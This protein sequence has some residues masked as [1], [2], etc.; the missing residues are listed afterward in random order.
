M[1]R[2]TTLLTL[3]MMTLAVWSQDTIPRLIISEVS[4]NNI[5]G[6]LEITNVGDTALNL[7]QFGITAVNGNGRSHFNYSFDENGN[8]TKLVISASR[9]SWTTHPEMRTKLSGILEAGESFV[10]APF[11]DS[12]R[13]IYN[14]LPYPYTHMTLGNNEAK[15]KFTD[16][17]VLASEGIF[18]PSGEF[19]N[20]PEVLAFGIDSIV[21][22]YDLFWMNTIGGHCL[23]YFPPNDSFVIDVFNSTVLDD[24][25][26]ASFNNIAIAGVDNAANN[27]SLVRKN[28][29]TK[30]NID[31][32]VSRGT[33]A[34]DSE[35]ILMP[36]NV[37]DAW[38][39][40][41]YTIGNH[42]DYSI[43][44]A[45]G[46]YDIDLAAG[47]MAVPWGTQGGDSIIHDLTL[48]DGMSWDYILDSDLA[49]NASED[50]AHILA[51][52]GDVLVL[53][54]YGNDLEE[55]SLTISVDEP[56]ANIARVYPKRRRTYDADGLQTGWTTDY[57]VSEGIPGK[58]SIWFVPFGTR[59]DTLRKYLEK[60]PEANWE[61]VWVDGV[62]R[63]DVKHGDILRVTSEDETVTR[64]YVLSV[65]DYEPSD[66]ADLLSITWPDYPEDELLDWI[67]GDTLPDFSSGRISYTIT[68]PFGTRTVPALVAKPQSLG[69]MVNI[70]P[71]TNLFGSA[72]ERT[73]T[74]HVT[75]EDDSVTNAYKVLFN[76]DIPPE[77]RQAFIGEPFISEI[78]V[79]WH[80][81]NDMM[82]IY[83][84][85][86]VDLDLSRYLILGSGAT[87]PAAALAEEMG[88]DS[89]SNWR[90]RY[91]KY[92]P[93]YVYPDFSEFLA[94]GWVLKFDP[95]VNPIVKPHETF[96]MSMQG[97]PVHKP[98][99]FQ[100]D[101]AARTEADFSRNLDWTNN[102][103]DDGDWNAPLAHPMNRDFKKWIFKILN[104]SVLNGTK[105]VGIDPEDYEL[106]D[107][108]GWLS[109]A[110]WNIGVGQDTVDVSGMTK[111]LWRKPSVYQGVTE[112]EADLSLN[113]DSCGWMA[114]STAIEGYGMAQFPRAL[115]DFGNHSADPVT[116]HL[117]KVT[118]LVYKVSTGYQGLQSIQGDMTTTTL[119]EFMGKVDKSHEDQVLEVHSATDGAVRAAEDNVAGGDTLHVTSANGENQTAYLL[120]NNPLDGDA[121]LEPV[122]GT[123][124]TVE[125]DGSTGTIGG[126][127]YG[128]TI[129]SV[130]DSLIV[131]D[132]ATLNVVDADGH[133]LPLQVLN[134][135]TVYVKT[136]VSDQVY[137]KVVAED[138]TTILYQMAPPSLSSDAYVVSNLFEVDQDNSWISNIPEGV[139]PASF[140]K[141]IIPVKGAEVKVLD[142][143]GNERTMGVMFIDDR[144]FVVS[145][146]GTNSKTYFLNFLN[147]TS[148][149]TNQAPS[150]TLAFT[151]TTINTGTVL[152]VS[153]LVEDDGNPVPPELSFHWE[154]EA[155][156]GDAGSVTIGDAS[157]M[158]TE[159]T[160]AERGTFILKAIADD[161]DKTTMELINVIVQ[162]PVG[163]EEATGPSMLMYP[164]PANGEVHMRLSNLGNR[165]EISIIDILGQVVYQQQHFN[166]EVT[167]DISE[168]KAG[169]YFVRLES[170]ENIIT[171]KLHITK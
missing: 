78:Q 24:E 29:V 104:D 157:Q 88:R 83:N 81:A 151:D 145:E 107:C 72:A 135:D 25:S 90:D 43:S 171:G 44:A 110:P 48:G 61:M 89:V 118:S 102:T 101:V 121:V 60:A 56:A 49:D 27:F 10:I 160:F 39:K 112:L 57:M 38:A 115:D 4:M 161:G 164:N 37:A 21:P 5:A 106:V 28:N 55:V 92:V 126:L 63:A 85:S 114:T 18:N 134:Y 150:V 22:Y 141:E 124:I 14:G 52:D 87:T 113:A 103:W 16:F 70:Q 1:R 8:K 69:A 35:W 119:T 75:S 130:L 6:W 159:V 152:A 123:T 67:R 33:S 86:D 59:V 32:D 77:E 98:D 132:L 163:I 99:R 74:I 54:A 153:V 158:A 148:F 168:I 169:V 73:T 17:P 133:I 154:V 143:L 23:W 20:K 146:D 91:K 105:E 84:P 34:E 108:Y 79:R 94:K 64:D 68:L 11:T 122:D 147:E 125:I 3:L 117:S 45:S 36:H 47:T 58:D 66:N 95:K 7:S 96:D 65:M 46:L 136:L 144:L 142:K 156:E 9:G 140:I 31:F 100:P 111:W 13:A 50:S 97:N 19:V 80:W 15:I 40:H 120:V 93:G 12:H 155:S 170:G 41:P 166:T 139:T 30:G 53:Y 137:F 138:K 127:K 167:L 116:A 62:E 26:R 129:S 162:W 128:Q 149:E 76:V 131:P 2:I 82:E 71:A 109:G 165:V 51:R 42:G